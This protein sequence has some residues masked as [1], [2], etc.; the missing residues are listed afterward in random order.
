MDEKE[1][2][3]KYEGCVLPVV[4]DRMNV[5]MEVSYYENFGKSNETIKTRVENVW[6]LYEGLSDVINFGFYYSFNTRLLLRTS[7][8]KDSTKIGH[9]HAHS[10]DEVIRE[11]YYNPESF[12]ID[13]EDYE[14]YSKQ[15]LL[16]LHR[17]QNFL[18]VAGIKD[19]DFVDKDSEIKRARSERVKE[20]LD[21]KQC[22]FKKADEVIEG[23]INKLIVPFVSDKFLG[24][25]KYIVVSVE[26]DYKGIVSV[27]KEKIKFID[28]SKYD[29]D[30]K[31]L[32]YESMDDYIESI[33]EKIGD[34]YD[35]DYVIVERYKV[36]EI[37]NS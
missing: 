22:R 33:R 5:Y 36:E 10:F 35:K 11:V 2:L 3:E 29:I 7:D 1:K 6:S 14:L 30:Y 23:K 9:S 26:G 28:I 20:L 21:Y 18:R 15:E 25:T 32:G 27:K 34:Y 24:D 13:E 4:D 8:G 19:L 17:L 37:F 31:M 12:S 16:F